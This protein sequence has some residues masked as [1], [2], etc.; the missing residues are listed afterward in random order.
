[1][2]KVAFTCEDFKIVTVHVSSTF[3]RLV[4]MPS[5]RC[6]EAR[7]RFKGCL[8]GYTLYDCEEASNRMLGGALHKFIEP[9][10]HGIGSNYLTLL[11][12]I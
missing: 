8:Q 10:I 5:F 4:Y 2:R 12:L 3:G 6:F 1:M 9:Q 7:L 11:L